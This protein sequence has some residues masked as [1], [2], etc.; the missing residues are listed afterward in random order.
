MLRFVS[1]LKKKLGYIKRGLFGFVIDI[2]ERTPK[3]SADIEKTIV[4]KSVENRPIEYYQIGQGTTKLMF[5][6]GIHGNEVGTV[7]LVKHLINFLVVEN[8]GLKNR[9]TF[10]VIP[11]LNPDGDALARKNPDYFRGGRIGRFN[12][13][14]VDLNR[15]FETPSFKKESI[16]SFGKRYQEKE[17][18][19]CGE[20]G[21]SEPE[22]KAFTDLIFKENIKIIF[23]FHN[24]GRDVMGNNLD[25]SQKLTRVYADKSR[26]RFVPNQE[27]VELQQSGTLKEWSEIHNIAYVEIEGSTRWGSDWKTQKEAIRATI[28]INESIL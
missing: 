3:I 20:Y 8:Q 16:Y 14:R 11:R 21:N 6:A 9:F 25:L 18:V 24:A 27:W 19:Y 2:I 10:F 26:F 4:G 17:K 22:T 7:K 28:E 1:K 15:N 13:R 5:M 12:A 23:A